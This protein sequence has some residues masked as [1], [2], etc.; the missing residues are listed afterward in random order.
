MKI[1][2]KKKKDR[3]E[4]EKEGSPLAGQGGDGKPPYSWAGPAPY[5]L[6]ATTAR[7][8]GRRSGK[9]P[10]HAAPWR[11]RGRGRLLT[12]GPSRNS[13]V[14]VWTQQGSRRGLSAYQPPGGRCARAAAGSTQALRAL[15]PGPAR[16]RPRPGPARPLF[17]PG[18]VGSI[19]EAAL[20]T[21]PAPGGDLR[22]H[23]DSA[24]G[25][26]RQGAQPAVGGDPPD[27]WAEPEA[28][29]P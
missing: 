24:G 11:S 7:P 20:P 8:P 16:P 28:P 27:P 17:S 19:G 25:Q 22:L 12:R 2:V 14:C 29:A 10:D 21:G 15:L 18:P 23:L 9:P 26:G 6:P 1:Q 13:F 3:K 5:A 4:L